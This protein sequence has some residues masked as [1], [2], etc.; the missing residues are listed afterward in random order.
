MMTVKEPITIKEV[1]RYIKY[2]LRYNKVYDFLRLVENKDLTPEV[3]GLFSCGPGFW[4]WSRGN[5][6]MRKIIEEIEKEK[7][8]SYYESTCRKFGFVPDL[9]KQI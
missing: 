2:C 6:K 1:K 4:D 5:K 9:T 7:N 3:E 8:I